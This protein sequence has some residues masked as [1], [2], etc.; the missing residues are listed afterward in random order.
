[1]DTIY[2][3]QIAIKHNRGQ[4]MSI[5]LGIYYPI[6]ST[7]ITPNTP[8]PP[9]WKRAKLFGNDTDIMVEHDMHTQSS[10]ESLMLT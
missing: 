6:L 4:T 1:M 2:K 7:P 9:L 5:I 3:S 8:P 10:P